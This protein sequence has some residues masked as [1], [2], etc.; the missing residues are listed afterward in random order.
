MAGTHTRRRAQARTQGQGHWRPRRGTAGFS[1][2]EVCMAIVTLTVT[3]VGI[4]GSI[5]AGDRLQYVNRESALA[6]DAARQMIETLRGAP[7][8]TVFAR[9]NGT[10]VDDPAGFVA[11]GADFAVDGLRAAPDDP[12]GLAGRIEFPVDPLAP[13]VLREDLADAGLDMPA[14]LDGDGVI[15]GAN[16]SGDYRLLPVRVQVR[17]TGRS[18]VRQFTVETV[19]CER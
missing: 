2:L 11:P 3:L 15:D 6:E 12:D 7:F 1:I 4:T 14:D 5:L 13:G 10:N 9:Y 19:L 18:G 16:H 8:A 17:W